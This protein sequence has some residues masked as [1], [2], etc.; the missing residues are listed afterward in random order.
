MK[1]TKLISK[2][3][4]ELFHVPQAE[5]TNKENNSDQQESN[6]ESF[7]LTLAKKMVE[8]QDAIHTLC[9]A[10][11]FWLMAYHLLAY[12]ALHALMLIEGLPLSVQLYGML[13]QVNNLVLKL[14]LPIVLGY[15]TNWLAIKML[16]HPR[17]PNKIWQGLV[18][19]RREEI[20]RSVASKIQEELFSAEILRSYL[21][22]I[23]N[24]QSKE[25]DLL[26]LIK[27]RM[28][29]IASSNDFR[30]DL[31]ILCKNLFNS[32]FE[33]KRTRKH[34]ASIVERNLK[35]AVRK[36]ILFPF[37]RSMPIIT[38]PIVQELIDNTLDSCLEEDSEMMKK[39]TGLVVQEISHSVQEFGKEGDLQD[40]LLEN[41]IRALQLVD[42]ESV[43]YQQ[44]Q[45]YDEAALE[46]LLTSGVTLELK[47]LQ[48]I[49]AYAG[50]V[51][52]LIQLHPLTRLPA[53][54]FM[55]YGAYR[56]KLEIEKVPESIEYNTEE[57]KVLSE[58]AS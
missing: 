7:S 43:I 56:I 26:D 48:V 23:M 14:F 15:G 9:K 29:H 49:G 51:V 34:L 5:L 25:G 6:K 54:A 31:K 41:L 44:L 1:L 30:Q 20:I 40:F 3:S 21:D 22:H 57:S 50:L 4:R 17:Y 36:Q 18:P 19:S 10:T 33:D 8:T 37:A 32:S 28:Q 55:A 58:S 53:L 46:E 12:P 38:L 2:W 24:S 52:G 42:V 16:F 35:D 13:E 47:F 27:T 45:K 39:V 11:I